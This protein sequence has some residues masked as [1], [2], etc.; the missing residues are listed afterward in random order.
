MAVLRD[1]FMAVSLSCVHS[2][3]F[4]LAP[5]PHFPSQQPLL[6]LVSFRLLEVG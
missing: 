4:P 5:R 6:D 2:V 1:S 3:A